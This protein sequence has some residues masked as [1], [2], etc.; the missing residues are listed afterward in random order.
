[1]AHGN[2]QEGWRSSNEVTM[3]A[4]LMPELLLQPGLGTTLLRTP[5]M[6]LSVLEAVTTPMASGFIV[7][8][9]LCITRCRGG[10]DHPPPTPPPPA[11]H[12][13]QLQESLASLSL[14]SLVFSG[15]MALPPEGEESPGTGKRSHPGQCQ[16][17]DEYHSCT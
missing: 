10:P 9:R 13:S 2:P 1:M 4:G 8:P 6:L 11:P 15:E 7:I 14:A 16:V 17:R 5:R 3:Q 12:P